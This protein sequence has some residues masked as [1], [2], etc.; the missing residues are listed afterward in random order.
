M[1]C[2]E[3]SGDTKISIFSGFD[4]FGFFIFLTIVV[5]LFGGGEPDIQDAIVFYLMK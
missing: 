1:D 5:V 4:M 3:K 2:E